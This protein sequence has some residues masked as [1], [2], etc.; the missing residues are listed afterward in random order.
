[1]KLSGTALGRSLDTHRRSTD[2]VQP[3]SLKG[4]H[5]KQWRL[6]SDSHTYETKKLCDIVAWGWHL[7]KAHVACNGKNW[8]SWFCS[9]C[10]RFPLY[11]SFISIFYLNM[12]PHYLPFCISGSLLQTFSFLLHSLS[13]SHFLLSFLSSRRNFFSLLHSFLYKLLSVSASLPLA[14]PSLSPCQSA[15]SLTACSF[16]SSA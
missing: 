3:T 1:M 11:F 8:P 10:P 12:C 5:C 16:S 13:L 6:F 7:K 9:V 2:F 15:K 4:N 14:P